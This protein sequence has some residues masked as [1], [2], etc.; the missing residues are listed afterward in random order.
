MDRRVLITGVGPVTPIGIGKENYWSSLIAG[1]SGARKIDFKNFDMEQYSTKI[2]CTVDDNYLSDLIKQSKDL[3]YF[4]RASQFAIAGTKLALEDAGFNLESIQQDKHR[5]DYRIKEMNPEQIGVIFGVGAQCMDLCENAHIKLLKHM[6]P[7][8]VSPF[9]L[10][11][12]MI[13]A[14]PVNVSKKFGIKGTCLDVSTACASSTHAI[15]SAY[16]QILYGDEDMVITGG[17]E[18]CITPLV[19]GCFVSLKAMSKRNNE[20][21]KASRPFDKDRD[22]FVMGEG[23]GIIILE[24]RNHALDRGAKIY[25]EITGYGST[26]DAYHIVAPEPEGSMQAKAMKDSLRS[27]GRFP[28]EI[29][30]VNAHGTSTP[31]ND[32]TE[33]KAIKKALGDAAYDVLV[34]STKSMTGHLIGASGGIEVIATALMIENGKIH[35]TLNFETAGEGCDLNY[36]PNQTIDKQ[37]FVALKNSFGFGG[38]NASL[39]LEKYDS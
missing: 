34:G 15:I 19:F 7:K 24:E 17:S 20:P 14:V 23:A 12:T 1:K 18:A 21:E 32:P 28:E 29:T 30:Y 36:V 4:G 10:P 33:S 26:S 16:K 2:A 39:L 6:G 38:Q 22:G 31:L 3:K 9:V 35:P 13:N 37:I 11:H 25:C 8:R 27:A 5:V